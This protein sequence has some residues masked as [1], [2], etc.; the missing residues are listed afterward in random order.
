MIFEKVGHTAFKKKSA[1]I[2]EQILQKIRSGE[3]QIGGKLP[4]ERMIAEQM[5]VSRPSLREAISALQIVGI[6]ESRP[7][8]GTYIASPPSNEDITLEA[9][10]V[11]EESESPFEV[12]QARKAMEIGVA[13]LAVE[14]ASDEDIRKIKDAWQHKYQMGRRG[15]YEA[16]IRSGRDLHLA[17]ARATKN[18]L[19]EKLMEK[20]LDAMNQPLWVNMR[21]AFYQANPDRIDRMVEIHNNIVNAMEARDPEKITRALEEDFDT[22]FQRFYDHMDDNSQTE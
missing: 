9:L 17:V 21:R 5:G 19:I 6:L 22:Q 16:Y 11:L 20:L 7:G 2:A 15:E 8:D 10:S 13:R 12:L 18:R 4:S 14:V 1:I 3:Y